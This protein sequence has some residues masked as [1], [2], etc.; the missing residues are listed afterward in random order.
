M[1]RREHGGDEMSQP[2]WGEPGYGLPGTPRPKASRGHKR[3]LWGALA[4]GVVG[5]SLYLWA[6]GGNTDTNNN[7]CIDGNETVFAHPWFALAGLVVAMVAALLAFVV[8]RRNRPRPPK[9]AT[10][11][12]ALT[13][14]NV[15]LLALMPLG[16]ACG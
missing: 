4:L 5:L 6:L 13:I 16:G 11:I 12:V 2:K 15:G 7:G 8:Y 9:M 3:A 1:A 10:V 14:G